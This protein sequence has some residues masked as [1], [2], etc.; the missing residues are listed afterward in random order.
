[1]YP[2]LERNPHASQQSPVERIFSEEVG[3]DLRGRHRGSSPSRTYRARWTP[4]RSSLGQCLFVLPLLMEYYGHVVDSFEC[5]GMIFPEG[6]LSAVEGPSITP[7]PFR[8]VLA[9]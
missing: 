8:T 1:V 3:H 9:P 6:L 2:R 7:A 4:P 5:E